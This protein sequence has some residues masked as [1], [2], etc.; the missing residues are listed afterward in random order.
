MTQENR[1]RRHI[2]LAFTNSNQPD[3]DGL[4]PNTCTQRIHEASLHSTLY[5]SLTSEEFT[6][7][8]S[9]ICESQHDDLIASGD[10]DQA[11]IEILR[12]FF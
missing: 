10:F 9:E 8:I 7:Q 2:R 5:P 12:A 4:I 1:N 3:V 11:E 6:R